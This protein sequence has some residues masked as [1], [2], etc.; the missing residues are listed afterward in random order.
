MTP[1]RRPQ[2]SQAQAGYTLVEMVVVA[3]IFLLIFATPLT[4]SRNVIDREEFNGLAIGLASWLEA[5]QRG[6]QRFSTGCTVTFST[7][8]NTTAGISLR[9]GDT[10][11]TVTPSNCSNESAF[12]IP[13]FRADAILTARF[14]PGTLSGNNIN[15][16]PRGTIVQ[17]LFSL[18]NPPNGPTVTFSL[19]K[20]NLARCVRITHTSGMVTIGANNRGTSCTSFDGSI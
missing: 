10:L 5:I 3:S 9:P 20:A 6:A 12:V 4:L 8:V 1:L 17:S 18:N 11:A 2:T 14:T 19:S 13:Q 15:F 7:G 16:T